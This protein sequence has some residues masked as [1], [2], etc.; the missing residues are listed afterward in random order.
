M[1]AAVG[2]GGKVAGA[3]KIAPKVGRGKNSLKLHSDAH[4]M[5]GKGPSAK[6]GKKGY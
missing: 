4:S 5:M 1:S 6:K 3:L 2:G